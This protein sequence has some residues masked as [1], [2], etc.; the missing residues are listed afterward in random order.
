MRYELC[1]G[2]GIEAFSRLVKHL[3]WVRRV[4]GRAEENCKHRLPHMFLCGRA[5][6]IEQAASDGMYNTMRE[7][8]LNIHMSES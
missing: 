1:N 3:D 6:Q 7:Y 2:M 8:I 4:E 5:G